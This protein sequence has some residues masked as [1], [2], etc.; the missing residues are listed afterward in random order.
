[1]KENEITID[2]ICE[3]NN[4][5]TSYEKLKIKSEEEYNIELEKAK[6]SY[7]DLINKMNLNY[8]I[9]L[10]NNFYIAK[11]N[12]EKSLSFLN[13]KF[14][15]KYDNVKSNIENNI[16]EKLKYDEIR[17]L[18][19]NEINKLINLINKLNETN[20]DE[21]IVYKDGSFNVLKDENIIYESI[22][23]LTSETIKFDENYFNS[24]VGEELINQI[25]LCEKNVYF[26]IDLLKEKFEK[27]FDIKNFYNFLNNEFDKYKNEL[28]NT[29]NNKNVNYYNKYIL[30]DEK[31]G[32]YKDYLKNMNSKKYNKIP[33]IKNGSIDFNETMTIG[34]SVKNVFS[35]NNK[36]DDYIDS[37]DKKEFP[38]TISF[39][40]KGNLL[41][42]IDK[43]YDE[44]INFVNQLIIEFL[45][46]FP[47]SRIH[48]KLI[49]INNIMDFS[50]FSILKKIN[51]NILLDGIVRDEK[52]L[53]ESI[54]KIKKIKFD[55]ED[56]LKAEG[57]KSF[58]DYNK[59]YPES[60][61]DTYLFVLIDF[62]SGV[63]SSLA[64]KI[65]NIMNNGNDDGVFTILT[66]NE[67]TDFEYNFTKE[68]FNNFIDV[69][70]E[71]SYCFV[72]LI[73]DNCIKLLFNEKEFYVDLLDDFKVD[74]LSEIVSK[75]AKNS[76]ESISRA[77]PLTNMFKYIDVENYKNIS[78]ELE[79]P[80]GQA[81]GNIQTLKLTNQSGPHAALI[82][83]SG[84][85]KSVLFHTL[86]LDACYKYSPDELNFYLLDF[87]G[88]VEFKYYENNKLPHIKIIGLT[89]DLYDGL[90]ILENINREILRRKKLF[91]DI[92]VSDIEGYYE[93]GKKIVRLF[94]II[95][96]IQEILV[97]N[98]K[99][100]EKALNVLSEILAIGRSF[101]IN[102]LWGSQSVPNISG[103]QQKL[104]QN[105]TN[106]I[107]LKV[108]NSDYATNFL[109]NSK[110]LQSIENLNRPGI[111][112]L[113]VIKDERTGSAVQ[114]FR[115]AYSEN[116][117]KRK[118]YVKKIVTKWSDYK[119]KDNLFVLND[120]LIPNCLMSDFYNDKFFNEK[121][122][123]K[124][125]ESYSLNLGT[126]YVSN[127]NNLLEIFNTK[128]RENIL[129]V[130]LNIDLLRD[131][132]GY[133]L[134][135]IVLN[136][137]NDSDY[138]NTKNK[139]YYIN[140]EGINPKYFDDLYN[141]LP[142]SLNDQ[143][144]INN[145]EDKIINLVKDLYQ[146]YL[147][148]KQY[149]DN[150]EIPDDYFSIYIFIHSI[151][152]LSDLFEENK[153]L[154]ENDFLNLDDSFNAKHSINFND[155]FITLLKNGSQYGIHFIISIDNVE[156]IREIRDEL[157][158]FNNKVLTIGTNVSSFIDGPSSQIP[159]ILSDKTALVCSNNEIKKIRV[160]RYDEQN[161]EYKKR[162]EALIKKIKNKE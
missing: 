61:M 37:N 134:L 128:K 6:K 129:F 55:A 56:K 19:N 118:E 84:S 17:D 23:S 58:F 77:I 92:G 4:K 98:E 15:I 97:R 124:S 89:N 78:K 21:N 81:G 107:C 144:E 91:T 152:S 39:R 5:I 114:E 146:G 148:R 22:L 117:E 35:G 25:F 145:N 141:L 36:N 16:D 139:I 75:L 26:L 11:E 160:Y 59:K 18:Y 112:G 159:L 38:I 41:I 162:I 46:S 86:I 48:F 93:Q 116:G 65:K 151:Q 94:I 104:M 102:V 87:K 156:S 70:S 33:D 131:M 82:G 20:F 108:A 3:I 50:N 147:D 154:E 76:I 126:D 130:G 79:I 2:F 106:R 69:V 52:E 96:E 67:C 158:K 120:D 14:K 99:I 47:A 12:L 29:K 57:L 111:M 132:M 30:E 31:Y 27:K 100:G 143:I 101:G 138:L 133:S 13:N 149:L 66:V 74:I 88:G 72:K 80:F 136:R 115:V 44:I 32:I 121:A 49:D 135:S 64:N 123:K 113:G 109:G 8:K 42:Y 85:G 28:I 51:N 60:P 1:M 137:L 73:D 125:F 10:N 157:T 161:D 140:K 71:K 54:E 153:N 142:K 110:S 103:I 34:Y 53:D 62:P 63:N 83:T 68:D 40:E 150:G 45:L 90:A 119:V 24:L 95:D 127:E 105:I 43:Y 122:V 9:Y 155:A 7:N